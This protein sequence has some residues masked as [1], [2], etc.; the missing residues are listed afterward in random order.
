MNSTSIQ[1]LLFIA[2]TYSTFISGMHLII[3]QDPDDDN[4]S[5]I[6]QTCRMPGLYAANIQQHV[7]D[8]MYAALDPHSGQRSHSASQLPKNLSSV[9][10]QLIISKVD[11][12]F[13]F[14]NNDSSASLLKKQPHLTSKQIEIITKKHN[15][16]VIVDEHHGRLIKINNVIHI[17][18]SLANQISAANHWMNENSDT[19]IETPKIIAELTL[20]TLSLIHELEEL[21]KAHENCQQTIADKDTLL[22]KYPEQLRLSTQKNIDLEYKQAQE[23]S[24]TLEEKKAF[25]ARIDELTYYKKAYTLF[26]RTAAVALVFYLGYFLADK[27]VK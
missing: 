3:D 16:I 7:T 8:K 12:S 17:E 26:L 9:T 19:V 27:I 18:K 14:W 2:A 13:A 22:K 23:A 25:E 21:N 4:I 5:P 15:E 20:Q 6:I 24:K 11:H 10:V 1:S